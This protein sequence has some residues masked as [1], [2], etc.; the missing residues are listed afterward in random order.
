MKYIEGLG[1]LPP[2]VAWFVDTVRAHIQ[3]QAHEL[4][5]AYHQGA[6]PPN[7]APQVWRYDNEP[8]QEPPQMPP[9]FRPGAPWAVRPAEEVNQPENII[10]DDVDEMNMD[11]LDQLLE[12]LNE[13]ANGR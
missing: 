12:R 8:L 4:W 2:D 9:V 7:E 1:E 13:D 3:K 6:P 10:P 5:D 11:E